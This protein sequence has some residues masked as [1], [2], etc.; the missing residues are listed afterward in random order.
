MALRKRI[1]APKAVVLAISI[2]LEKLAAE[3]RA[4]GCPEHMIRF[5]C[6]PVAS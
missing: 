2:E 6:R 3:M 1:K 4:E 5:V